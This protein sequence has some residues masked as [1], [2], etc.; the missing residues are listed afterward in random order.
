MWG[1]FLSEPLRIVA[2]V[3]RY[4]ANQLMRRMPVLHR[5]A[6]LTSR[7]CLPKVLRGIR[8]NFSCLSPCDGQIAYVLLTRAPVAGK[9]YCYSSRCPST[10]MC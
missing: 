9:L 3:G 2:L 8:Q 1:T 4:P 7:R 5:I 6:P 10:C